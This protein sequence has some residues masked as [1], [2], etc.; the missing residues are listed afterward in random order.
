MVTIASIVFLLLFYYG[1]RR[2]NYFFMIGAG[3]ALMAAPVMLDIFITEYFEISKRIEH[4]ERQSPSLKNQS[5]KG[6]QDVGI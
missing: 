3:I 5:F 2:R 1:A 4:V 6:N